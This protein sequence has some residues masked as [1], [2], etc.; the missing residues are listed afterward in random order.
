MSGRLVVWGLV[1]GIIGAAVGSALTSDV[2]LHA[3]RLGLGP[4]AT[5]AM[6]WSALML[7][8]PLCAGL[9]VAAAYLTRPRP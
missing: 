5:D 2:Y 9:G 4:L 6:A 3:R 1:G 7:A 8:M